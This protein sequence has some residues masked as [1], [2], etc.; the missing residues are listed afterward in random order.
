MWFRYGG[1]TAPPPTQP[2]IIEKI[3]IAVQKVGQTDYTV[4]YEA[5]TYHLNILGKLLF[6]VVSIRRRNGTA[7]YSTT[8][9]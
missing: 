4:L 5:C 2:P 9:Y 1:G 3:H 8:D 7:A 6:Y